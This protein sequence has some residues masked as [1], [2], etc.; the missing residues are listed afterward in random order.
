MVARVRAFSLLSYLAV[1][2]IGTVNVRG[3]ALSTEVSF[4]AAVWA[5]VY[6]TLASGVVVFGVVNPVEGWWRKRH[7]VDF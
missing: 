1:S 6:V 5:S 4:L 2:T 7:F 3:V